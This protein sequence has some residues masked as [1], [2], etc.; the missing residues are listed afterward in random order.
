MMFTLVMAI[1]L[2]AV[3]VIASQWYRGIRQ[4]PI[5]RHEVTGSKRE[6]SYKPQSISVIIAAKDEEEKIA[7]TVDSLFSQ[8]CAAHEV[9]VVNDR[10]ADRTGDILDRLKRDRYPDLRVIHIESLPAGWLGKNH[11]LYQ[12]WLASSGEWLLFADADILFFPD[13]LEKAGSFAFRQGLDHL[14]LLPHNIGGTLWYRIFYTFWS[15]IGVW[16]F[17]AAGHAGVGAFNLMKRSV[18]EAAGT[19]EAIA[20]RPD[21]DI[22]LGGKIKEAGYAQ[23]LGFGN[24]LIFIQWYDSLRAMIRGLE[25]NLFAFMQYRLWMVAAATVGVLALHVLPFAAVFVP[26]LPAQILGATVLLI[27]AGMFLL[28]RRYFYHPF[29]YVLTV[30]LSAV[31]FLYCLWRST[32]KTLAAG[33]VEW[34]GTKY[35]LKELRKREK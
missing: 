2:L 3:T 30:P 4:M 16:N 19:H 24:G 26:V 21:D 9:I 18:Y 33:G 11:A 10:S 23:Q 25:K 35:S 6:V 8:T 13:A 27:F 31:I 20:L 17:V 15:I 34:R 28:N 29:W 22:K 32:V 7:D 5:V 14:A 12:G 1:V